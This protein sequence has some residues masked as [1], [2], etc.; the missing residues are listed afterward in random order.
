MW[1]SHK[2]K[3]ASQ[4][5]GYVTAMGLIHNNEANSQ[6]QP[7]PLIE[8]EHIVSLCIKSKMLPKLSN[9]KGRFGK[10]LP[11]NLR[12]HI[13]TEN[14]ACGTNDMFLQLC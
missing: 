6:E 3:A 5:C 7:K 1:L 4:E 14:R 2:N 13:G 12:N 10:N 9:F 8:G 11:Q